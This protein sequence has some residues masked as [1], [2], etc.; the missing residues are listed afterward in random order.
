MTC[1]RLLNTVLIVV[2]MTGLP[3]P[4]HAQ[5]SGAAA[6]AKAVPRSEHPR[7]D[8]VRAQWQT[9]N[10]AWQ[11]EFDDRVVGVDER[12]YAPDRELKRAIVVPYAFQSRLSGIADP[13]FHDV[14][15][16]RRTFE[17]P[18]AWKGQ[19]VRLHFGAVDYEATVWV[20]GQMVGRHEGGHTPFAFD[21]TPL[22]TSARNV[23]TVRAWDPS[24]DR[25]LP[26][27]KQYWKEKSEAIWYTRTTGIWQPVWIEAVPPVHVERL[28]VTPDVDRSQVAVEAILNQA[29][30][31]DHQLRVTAKFEKDVD[32]VTVSLRD[33]RPAATLTL[34][35]QRL[36]S[37]E[38]PSLYDLV[39]ELVDASGRTVDRVESYFGQRKVH[40]QNDRVWLNNRPYYLR[41]V[42]DHG[43][44]PESLLT[45]PTD[46]AIQYDVKMTK[47]F[48]FNGARKHQKVEDPRWLYWC[49][50]LGLLVWGE[51]ANAYDVYHDR[52]VARFVTEWMEVVARDY[53]H[54]SV[55]GWVPINESWGASRALLDPTEQHHLRSLYYLT[56]SLDAS[57]PVVDNDG[58]E[59]TD[60]TDLFTLHDYA[61]TGPELTDK[62]QHLT[63]DR[64]RIP[65]NG[66]EALVNGARYN[67]TP[68]L[69]TEFGGVAFK[70]ATTADDKA[71]GYQGIEPTVEALVVRIDG[72]VKALRANTAFGGY[73]YTQLT[74]VEQE[75]NGLM[76]YDRKPKAAPEVFRKI[77][78]Q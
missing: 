63:T 12:W 37:P 39:V 22:L 66:R 42:L 46:E 33:S 49:D 31:A 43:Y 34:R 17:V 58:W 68:L 13:T 59:H 9:L 52:Y 64:S 38:R 1:K 56:K 61:R 51:M 36:W 62:Y 72:Q 54:P 78:A 5:T 23:V 32:V 3:A 41:F 77:F 2:A 20:N 4:A 69:M 76:T 55:V 67:G 73:C 18:A 71:W 45:P 21:V 6:S 44:W 14:V 15:W 75:I 8:L 24:T 19:R 28:R 50:K 74:D 70:A 53:N 60:A 29:A 7:P 26:R 57:R 35:D 47:A 16:Y 27:G 25:A 65:R 48:G 10:G 40:V 11:F 30:S